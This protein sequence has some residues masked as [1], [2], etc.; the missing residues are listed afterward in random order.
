MTTWGSLRDVYGS[1]EQVPILLALAE[2]SG[3]SNSDVWD[4]LWGRLCHQGTVASASYA[5]LPA[6]AAM[7]ARHEAAGSVPAMHLAADIIASTDG[8]EPP[9]VI[10]QRYESAVSGLRA[11][12]EENLSHAR[13]DTE[14]VYGL[15]ALM[16]FENGGVW[17]RNLHFIADDEAEFGCPA[18]AEDLLLNL[19]TP[20]FRVRSFADASLAPTAAGPVEPPTQTPEGRLLTLARGE[21]RADVAERLLTLFGRA[22]CPR[23]QITFDI[24][25]ALA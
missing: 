7:S 14:F 19:D 10:R 11:I 3:S 18:C 25:T 9:A 24:A 22:T 12:A 1:A 4:D 2:A 17:Q 13:D 16:A 15:Q 23:C 5:A 6:L 21:G 8:P 20:P